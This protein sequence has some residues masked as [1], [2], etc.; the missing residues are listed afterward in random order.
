MLHSVLL[1]RVTDVSK[2]CSVFFF[3][4]KQSKSSRC[5]WRAVTVQIDLKPLLLDNI[6]NNPVSTPKSLQFLLASPL[7]N[8]YLRH[9]CL[10]KS[11]P[12]KVTIIYGGALGLVTVGSRQ[13]A[14]Y[15]RFCKF[16]F[17]AL[18]ATSVQAYAEVRF[19]NLYFRGVQKRFYPALDRRKKS[20]VTFLFLCRES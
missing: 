4:G 13:G 20:F 5:I 10:H 9:S 7:L 1:W 14:F 18:S 17:T 6:T 3:R 12:L 16:L 2:Q 8:R 15:F 11:G 19:P